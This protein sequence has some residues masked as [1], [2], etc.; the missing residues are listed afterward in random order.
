MRYDAIVVGGGPA[1]ATAALTLAKGGARVLLLERRRL[2]RYKPC[3]GCLSRR[4]ERWL[5]F[6]P[7]V[8]IEERITGLTFTWRGRDAVEATF[9]EPVA[10][11]IWRNMFDQAL[12]G[13]AVDAGA[14]LQDGQTIRSARTSANHVEVE[15]AG[16]TV[17]ADFLVGADGAYSVVARDLFPDRGQPGLA[18]LDVELPLDEDGRGE[19]EGSGGTGCGARAGRVRLGLS[20]RRR[21]L[22]RCGGRSQIGETGP[23]VPDG[24]SELDRLPGSQRHTDHRG[25]DSDSWQRGPLASP[26]ARPSCR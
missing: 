23:V 19:A 3:G 17:T 21:G 22:G 25:V 12:C 11:M 15:I 20:E 14:E 26:R 13:R 4:V 10:L 2:P 6:D 8:L 9:S 18:A 16:R 5:P 1:G 24:L 7:S